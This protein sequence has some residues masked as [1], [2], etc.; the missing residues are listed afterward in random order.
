MHIEELLMTFSM[1]PKVTAEGE[2]ASIYFAL[3]CP[4]Q[5]YVVLWKCRIVHLISL[6]PSV[7]GLKSEGLYRMSGFSDSVE[8]VKSAF[9][10]GASSFDTPIL[11]FEWYQTPSGASHSSVLVS[12]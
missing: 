9:D 1:L 4:L 10:R 5:S 8:D 6:Y 3:G 2:F 7:I 12:S 11:L